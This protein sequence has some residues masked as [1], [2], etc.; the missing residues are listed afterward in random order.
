[1]ATPV[2]VQS[3]RNIL[4]WSEQNLSQCY[5]VHHVYQPGPDRCSYQKL[6]SIPSKDPEELHSLSA[7]L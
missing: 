4:Q 5:Y 1:M 6:L 3:Y 2:L 7:I